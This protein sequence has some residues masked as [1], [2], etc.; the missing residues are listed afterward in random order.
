MLS[1]KKHIGGGYY[2]DSGDIYFD[3]TTGQELGTTYHKVNAADMGT[4]K[5]LAGAYAKDKNAGFY[6]GMR[7][8]ADVDSLEC[9]LFNSKNG[10][11]YAK[12]KNNVYYGIQKISTDIVNFKLIEN[13]N[14]LWSSYALY[15]KDNESVFLRGDKLINAKPS[16]FEILSSDESQLYAKDDE[17]VFYGDVMLTS[18]DAKTFQVINEYFSKDAKAVYCNGKF[19]H[20]VDAASFKILNEYYYK[21]KQHAFYGGCKF[22]DQTLNIIK[23]ADVKTFEAISNIEAKDQN[24]QYVRGSRNTM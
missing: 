3:V 23:D 12:D 8:D 2:K 14:D 13:G 9:I 22:Q 21:D 17:H 4:F 20:D 16:S 19:V 18:V 11:T 15:G 7:F 24:Y 1:G 6:K 10:S 5:Y